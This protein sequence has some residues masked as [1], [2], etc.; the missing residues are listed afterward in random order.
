ML[1][2]D[3]QDPRKGAQ[4][5]SPSQTM[6]P[7]SGF[8]ISNVQDGQKG[9]QF[10]KLPRLWYFVT[11]VLET[12]SWWN[13]MMPDDGSANML[14]DRLSKPILDFTQVSSKSQQQSPRSVHPESHRQPSNP[15]C[16][17]SKHFFLQLP[18]K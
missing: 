15:L 17:A 5:P 2:N 13:C 18:V 12:N 8:W 6:P 1:A 16:D 9:L 10:F 14:A 3:L 7:T 11:V 4:N